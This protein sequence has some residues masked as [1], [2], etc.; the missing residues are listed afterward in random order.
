MK[1]GFVCCFFGIFVGLRGVKGMAEKD[2]EK[3]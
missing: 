3:L 1:G 2:E